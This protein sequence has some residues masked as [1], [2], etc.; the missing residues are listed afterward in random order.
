VP[1]ATVAPESAML[2]GAVT[3]KVPPQIEL[4]AL[5]TVSPVGSVS[6]KPTPVRIV[7]LPAGLVMV[8]LKLVDAFSPM[9]L[10]PNDFEIEGGASTVRL[11]F[12]VLPVPP[13]LEVTFPVVLV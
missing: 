3:V 9:A 7:G 4:V 6:V 11:A 2:T 5:V 1:V 12:A 8:K 10:A 13:L